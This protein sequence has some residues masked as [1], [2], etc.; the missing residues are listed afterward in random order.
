MPIIDNRYI[1]SVIH[2]LSIHQLSSLGDLASQ[3]M[4]SKGRKIIQKLLADAW[5]HSLT[6]GCNFMFQ[7]EPD[8]GRRFFT[9]S[10]S[11]SGMAP[12]LLCPCSEKVD[13]LRGLVGHK[14]YKIYLQQ[15]SLK[16]KSGSRSN[17]RNNL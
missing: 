2:I 1:L 9:V 7:D 16:L 15:S 17:T 3:Y 11:D 12:P 10:K 6:T 4:Q 13:T 5:P 14:Y 8:H